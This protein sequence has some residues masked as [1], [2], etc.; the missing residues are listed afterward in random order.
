MALAV[1]PGCAQLRGGVS[2]GAESP[3]VQRLC[4][5]GVSGTPLALAAERVRG[6]FTAL[7]EGLSR[8]SG[9][10][11]VVA[12]AR[13]ATSPAA[14]CALHLPPLWGNGHYEKTMD[15]FLDMT[16]RLRGAV[17]RRQRRWL[18]FLS[19]GLGSG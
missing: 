8:K 14:L 6:L 7:P 5:G 9:I 13:R 1:C 12:N 10:C 3:L 2:N 19:Y 11:G 16:K 18:V 17:A 4:Q 15:T